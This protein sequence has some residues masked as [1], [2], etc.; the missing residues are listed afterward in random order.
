MEARAAAA[1]LGLLFLLLPRQASSMSLNGRTSREL[2]DDWDTISARMKRMA[3]PNRRYPPTHV[4]RDR[5]GTVCSDVMARNTVSHLTLQ[6][7]NCTVVEGSVLIML[8]GNQREDFWN[9][10]SFP[11]LRE[12]TGYLLLYR[13]GGLL[14]LGQLFPN[15]AVIRGST[16]FMNYALVVFEM[17]HLQQLGLS[18]LTAILRGSVRVEKNPQL[19]FTDTVNWEQIMYQNES[20]ANMFMADNQDP[21]ECPPCPDHCPLRPSG[22]SGQRLCWDPHHCQRVCPAR[23]GGPSGICDE[24]DKNNCCDAKCLGGCRGASPGHLGCVACKHYLFDG[25]CVTSCPP[26]TYKFMER[27]CVGEAFCRSQKK[28]DYGAMMNFIPFKGECL[29]YCPPNYVRENGMCRRCSG[30]CPKIC[31]GFLVDSAASAQRVKDCTYING[32]LH[33]QIPGAGNILKELEEYLHTVQEIRDSLKVT[34]SNQLISLNFL[35]NLHTIHGENLERNRYSLLVLDNQNLQLL[36]D[37]SNRLKNETLTLRKG[38]VFFHLNPKLCLNHIEVLR[39]RGRVYQN[40]TDDDVSRSTNGD[41]AACDVHKLHVTIIKIRSRG[42][43][44]N[45]TNE[46]E[47]GNILD[48][49]HLLGYVTYYREAPHRNVTLYDGRDACKGDVWN[50][51][52]TEKGHFEQFISPLKPFTQYAFYVKAYILPPETKG[53]QSDIFY[54]RTDPSAP[55]QPLMLKAR[56]LKDSKAEIVWQPPRTPNGDVRFYRVLGEG[57]VD[58]PRSRYLGEGRNYCEHPGLLGGGGKM[59]SEGF[60]ES[61]LEPSLFDDKTSSIS[62]PEEKCCS[63]A[64]VENTEDKIRNRELLEQIVEDRN[65]FENR[66]QNLAFIKKPPSMPK[67]SRRMRRSLGDKEAGSN[68]LVAFEGLVTN[69]TSEKEFHINIPVVTEG[70]THNKKAELRDKCEEISAAQESGTTSKT[71]CHWVT[72]DTRLLQGALHRFTEYSIRVLA[73]YR[74][75]P[76]WHPSERDCETR[77]LYGTWEM[78]CSIEAI[79]SIRTMPVMEAD[80]IDTSSVSVHRENTTSEDSSGGIF[81]KWAPPKEPNGIVVSYQI[82]YRMIDQEK[83]KAI[84]FCVPHNEYARYGGRLVHGL[85]AGNYSFRVMASSLAGPGNWTQPVYFLIPEQT[86]GMSQGVLASVVLVGV[87]L[88]FSVVGGLGFVYYRKMHRPQDP[89]MYVSINPEYVSSVYEPDEWEVPRDSIELVKE[90]GQGS[91][92]MVYEGIAK[93]LTPEVDVTKCAVK[94]VNE[95]A[96]IHERIE[97]LQEA[98]VMKAFSCH[99][100]VKLLGV[101]SKGQPVY[102]IMELMSNGDLKG[103]LRSHRPEDEDEVPENPSLKQILQMAAEIADGMAYL[104]AHKFV[105]RDLAARNCMVAEDLTVKI[106][107]FGMTRDIYETD[108]YRKGGKGLLPVRW[109][110]P[111]SLKDG[112]F[113]SQSDIWSYGVVLW[114]MATL[115]SQPYQGLANEQVLKYVIDGGVMQK[116]ENCPAKLYHIMKLCWTRNPRARPKFVEVIE[117]LLEDVNDRFRKVSFYHT[118]E[119]KTQSGRLSGSRGDNITANRHSSNNNPHQQPLRPREVE[120]EEE[121]ED[122]ATAESP[123]RHQQPDAASLQEMDDERLQR[124]FSDCI[125]DDDDDEPVRAERRT[126]TSERRKDPATSLPS[127]DGSK[128]SKVS[129]VSNGSLANGRICFAMP[130]GRTTAC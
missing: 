66:I 18:R 129:S 118:S 8:M 114:E 15:L 40:W 128:G 101:V 70:A 39:K 91:F 41:R 44:I 13:A 110:A 6:L 106:G 10:V 116:P 117:M 63:C 3:D 88:F 97:F 49:R 75:P 130:G 20:S 9:G 108:Y 122:E 12:I 25:N 7:D 55:S 81:V 84:Q 52:D 82:E 92:G 123:L 34:R 37:W 62:K 22:T 51:I 46:L 90:L 74:K 71:F 89:T 68:G 23:C 124:C 126:S 94:T 19:C 121:E 17:E 104:A 120:E 119:L 58:D 99:H 28:D 72:N 21:A 2:H 61:T 31:P 111:E 87:M 98:S 93:N 125:D 109:M 56:A 100:V 77:T 76:D 16:L 83:F 53:A 14:S 80:D 48:Q 11:M 35:K 27:R 86:G 79:T 42:A 113:T 32:S 127:S 29:M 50:M 57:E 102:V 33:I 65:S 78:C 115:A 24:E 4:F 54:F 36:W 73:C 64:A 95:S 5:N 60:T 107:D 103:Y 30:R 45:W 96:S 69:E 105:H 112:I 26:N 43:L 85:A 1:F 38:T 67:N 59:S 47:E